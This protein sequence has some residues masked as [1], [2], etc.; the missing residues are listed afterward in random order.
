MRR[1]AAISL[2]MLITITINS[3]AGEINY[4]NKSWKEVIAE[5]GRTHKYIFVD[6]YTEWCG[7]CKT[8]DKQTMTD[9]RV[10]KELETKYVSVK[11]DMEHG[12]G[13]LMAMKYGISGYPAFLFFDERGQLIYKGFGYMR[14]D[15]FL[16]L[17]SKVADTA[18]QQRAPGMSTGL[19]M[20]YPAF[21]KKAF[22]E[23]GK[24]EFPK[25]EEVIAYLDS[26]TNLYSEVCW[27]VISR[28]DVGE[29]YT[30]HLIANTDKYL[31]LYGHGMVDG[32]LLEVLQQGLDYATQQRNDTIYGKVME[33]AAKLAPETAE[34]VHL[35]GS[36]AYYKGTQKWDQ[37]HEVL[38]NYLAKKGYKNTNFINEQCW[39]IYETCTDKTLL[40]A[41]TS[42]MK[43][44]VATE[45]E[46]KYL[47]TYA[48]LLYK[49]GNAKDAKV[50]ANKAIAAGQAKGVD[51]KQTEEL[52]AKLQTNK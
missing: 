40:N 10:V 15:E 11:L 1:I 14:A 37:L 3:Y 6:C 51:V 50:W 24:R 47:D 20:N 49:T 32:K 33:L 9:E 34:N 18:Q 22:A 2:L 46:Y 25:Q 26:Q 48:W 21:Y 36:I 19:I 43:Q 45:P 44:V 13:V 29:K 16:K 4:N 23:N 35:Y 41:A 39:A 17:L 8:M 27:A 42:W 28:F 12:E 52:M 38:K 30:R 5:A 7:W 31:S